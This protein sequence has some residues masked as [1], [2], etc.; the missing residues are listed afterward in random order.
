MPGLPKLPFLLVG[1]LLLFVAPRV[2]AADDAELAAA[3]RAASL[4]AG[5]APDSPEAILDDLAVDPLELAL[6]S[7]MITLVDGLGADLLDRVRALRRKLALELGVVMPPV[8]TRDNFDLPASTYAIKLNGVEVARGQAP[9]GMVLA[10]GDGLEGLPGTAGSEPVFGLAG[11]WIA[12]ELRGQ[13]EL[14]GATVVDRS[15]VIITHLSEV[16]RTHAGRLLG[17]EEVAALTKAV[18]R[19]HPVVVEDLTP[20]MLSLGEVQRVLHA[21]LEEG[22]SIRDLVR[23]FEALSLAAKSGTEPDRLVEAARLALAPAITASHTSAGTL[24]CS[25]WTRGCSRAC[26]NR[27]GPPSPACSCCRPGRWRPWSPTP[28]ASTSSCSSRGSGR[29]WCARRRSGCRCAG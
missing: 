25:C 23:I 27:C 19:T 22:V 11:K 12:T 21:L 7:D 24:S 16:V 26:W 29:C 4:A 8:R 5:P 13:A 3:I 9:A 1:G 10:I 20:A 14:L 18:Q 6:S 28:H 17:R 2:A 15:S